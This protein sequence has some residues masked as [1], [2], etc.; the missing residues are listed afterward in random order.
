[1]RYIAVALYFVLA[2]LAARSSA[3]A[4]TRELSGIP[5]IRNYIMDFVGGSGSVLLRDR[6]GLLYWG[7]ATH[8]IQQYDGSTWRSIA[9]NSAILRLTEDGQGKIWAGGRGDFGYLEPD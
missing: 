3:L 4:Q 1:M 7:G 9:T 6:R 5:L 2:L 8:D